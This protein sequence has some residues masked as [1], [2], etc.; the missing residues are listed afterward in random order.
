MSG[1]DTI[2]RGLIAEAYENLAERPGAFVSVLA[3]RQRLAGRVRNLDAT[4]TGMYREQ[5]INLAPQSNQM[6]LTEAERAAGIA[7]GG[8]V[9]HRMAWE[10]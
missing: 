3:L 5:V 1:T 8:E 2:E 9:K 7:C 4:L 6:A 10:D